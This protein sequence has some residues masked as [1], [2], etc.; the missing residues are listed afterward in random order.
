MGFHSISL[1][2]SVNWWGIQWMLDTPPTLL[3]HPLRCLIFMV[4]NDLTLIFLTLYQSLFFHMS[5]FSMSNYLV[6]LSI[7]FFNSWSITVKTSY[8]FDSCL[9]SLFGKTNNYGFFWAWLENSM[10]SRL[11]GT[12][13]I[14]LYFVHN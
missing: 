5:K 7:I 6:Y 1:R 10:L 9:V 2:M 8:S 3:L 4:D 12:S 11:S 14:Y 13:G